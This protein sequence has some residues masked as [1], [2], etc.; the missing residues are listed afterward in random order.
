MSLQV[1]LPLTKDLRNQGLNKTIVTNNGA[2]IDAAGKIGNCYFLSAI[3]AMCE[4]PRLISQTIISTEVSPD[5]IYKVLNISILRFSIP[6]I[7]AMA[8][9]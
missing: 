3:A 4:F 1:W 2:T 6:F 7:Q 9:P 5:G 8:I